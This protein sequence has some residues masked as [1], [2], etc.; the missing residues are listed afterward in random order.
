MSQIRETLKI[1]KARWPEV[2]LI[3]GLTVLLPFLRKL[4][5]KLKYHSAL[6]LIFLPIFLL[7]ALMVITTMLYCGFIRT[8][9]LEG[10]KRQAIP[11]LL[12]TGLHFL[13]RIIVLGSLYGIPLLTLML[14]STHLV[15]RRVES[16]ETD[17][18]QNIFLIHQL[19]V[20]VIRI[21]L[22][23]FIIFIPALVIVLDCGA[24]ESFKFIKKC[25][26]SD[27]KELIALFCFQIALGFVWTFLR[28]LYGAATIPPFTFRI[29]SSITA[30]FIGLIIAVMAVRF[31]A[32]LDLAYDG[33]TQALD[34][35]GL[36]KF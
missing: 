35:Q 15:A 30:C 21:I 28:T 4:P 34:S 22:M 5:T 7:L 36:L 23:K 14:L 13:W 6:N 27:A 25:R 26:L 16:G 17:T 12:R 20:S 11:V 10:Q 32:S 2:V 1:L 33:Q 9:Y 19:L 3:I 18:V 29:G 8:V 24:F 31:V